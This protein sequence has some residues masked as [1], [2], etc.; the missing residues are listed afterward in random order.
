MIV[1]LHASSP[2][3][4]CPQ[5]GTAGSRVHSRY[6]R[7]I[8]DVACGGRSLVFKVLVRK[9]ICPN[10]ACSQRIFAERFPGFVQRYARMTDRLRAALQVVGVTT[11]GAD[12]ARILS[13]LGMP[14]TGKTLI[15]HVLRLPLPQDAPVRIAGVDEWAWKKGAHYG[16]ILVDLEHHRVAALLPDRS[17]E[18]TAAW[19]TAHPEVDAVSRD[20]GKLFREA[21]TRG[22]PQARQIADRFHLQQNFAEALEDFFRR[23][24]AVV[25]AVAAPLAAKSPSPPKAPAAQRV[26][27]ERKRRHAKR[28]R[29]HHQ[30]WKLFRAGHRIE[31]IARLVGVGNQAV[32][33]ALKHEQPPAPE[34]R[35]RTHHVTDP[36]LGYLCE[37]WNA[38]CHTA[39]QLYEEMV[40]QGYTGS[41]RSVD[42]IVAKV[43]PN[44]SKPV[45]RQTMTQGKAPSARSVALMMVRPLAHRTKEQLAFID[46]LCQRDSTIAA[47]F[48]LTQEFGDLLRERHRA[49]DHLYQCQAPAGRLLCPAASRSAITMRSASKY[50]AWLFGAS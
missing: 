3:A 19:F 23:Y 46:Q 39:T 25:K 22:A 37:R 13:S 32:Y 41:K 7:T 9:W 1:S 34:T 28:V 31:E 48:S 10:A 16:T 42:R 50:C 24:D 40:A 21:A 4:P 11:N 5:C 33:R 8:A 6:Q 17:V 38:G 30:I 43:R 27:Q 29:H 12:A 15:R 44:G 18:T 45:S 26:E 20:R 35:R 47:A 2:A 14:T 49:S 36:Y